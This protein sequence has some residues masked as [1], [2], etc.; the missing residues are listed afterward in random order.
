M[1]IDPVPAVPAIPTASVTIQPTCAVPTGTI[2]VTAPLG[3]IYEYSV[4]GGAYQAGV[5]FAG[6]APGSH[7]VTA[8][9]AASP[10]CISA[11]TAPL[12]VD[13]VLAAPAIP[14]VAGV[15]QPTC[16]IPT[17]TIV[18]TTQAGVEYSVGAGYQASETFTGLI[19][20][21]YTLTVRSI[22]DNTCITPAAS[23]V[24]L[25]AAVAPAVPTVASTL[26]P[27]CGTPTGTIVFT[28]QAG[29][30]YSVGAGYQVSETFAGLTPGVYTLS[31][32]SI[33]DNSCITP[34]AATVT[35]NAVP[36]APAIP[37]VSGVT[38]PTCGT[39][40]GTIVFTTQAGV[41]YSV[42]AGYQVSETFAGL[43][44][45]V[46]TLTVRSIADNTCIT[47]AAA[48]VTIDP[49]PSSPAAPT[50][51]V[52]I[53]PT[54]SV[55][56]G[57]I[58]VT[59][60]V[61]AQYEYNIDGGS[62][63][64]GV[65]FVGLLPGPH[66][67]TARL[68]AS[69]ACVSPASAVL[70]VNAVPVAPASPTAS[71]TTQ[72]SCSV[73]TG[74]VVVTAPLGAAYEYSINGGAYQTGVTFAGL[75]PGIYTLRTRLVA[76]PTCISAP[77]ASLTVNAAPVPPT[78]TTTKVDVL[79]NG[80][81]TGSATATASGGTGPYT[82]SWNT[83]PVQTTPTATGLAA[84]TYIVTVT[85]ALGCSSTRSVTIDQPA[86]LSI[87]ASVTDATCP[88]VANGNIVLSISGGTSP[89]TTLWAD[90]FTGTNR[91][92]VM[93]G[94]Y[95]VIVTD[96]NSCA[97]SLDVIVG[98][99]GLNCLVIPEVITPNNDGKNDVWIIGNID[100]YP[101][102]EVQVYTRWGKL[103][104]ISRNILS[105]PWDGTFNGRLLPTDS[106]HYILHLNDGS[107]PLSGVITIIR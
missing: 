33:A 38:Q 105:D 60:P 23:T 86:A 54:C 78:I 10:T 8:R 83:S 65:T 31:V 51:S 61:G 46:Y 67:L 87:S 15:T 41:E 94:T 69:P 59:A 64:S 91:P 49:V 55:P 37:T 43:I 17:G 52:T 66:T 89:Y 50:A 6:L 101:D 39:P 29:V 72:P 75:V 88:G 34:A 104:Y 21:V 35:I 80:N 98:L 28:T 44:P 70:T 47:P 24:T 58:V 22:A 27:T 25:T 20:G 76:S 14:T 68:I 74:T 32:R 40:T 96:I 1:T 97:S 2:V 36:A 45:G 18:F 12:T 103:V 4:D 71:V 84:G 26:Q 3:A 11:A 48:T 56:T 7:T 5:T 82:F 42:G 93:A 79:C 73:P 19:P 9:L 16:G 106:Y 77:G 90:G 95:P 85:D 62:Y 63:Q 53:Q 100:L 92:L 99:T 81:T 30:E 13:P 57:T 102:A 107:E